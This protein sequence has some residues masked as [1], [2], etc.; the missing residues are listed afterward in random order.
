MEQNDSYQQ[1]LENIESLQHQL[2]LC[3]MIEQMNDQI[4]ENARR[5]IEEHFDLCRAALIARKN[6]LLN[7]FDALQSEVCNIFEKIKY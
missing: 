6:T 3:A 7:Q 2:A 1:L 4:F 5:E